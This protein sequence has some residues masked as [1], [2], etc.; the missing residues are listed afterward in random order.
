MAKTKKSTLVCKPCGYGVTVSD[1][2]S[3]VVECW[4]CGVELV[5]EKTVA[6]KRALPAKKAV[7]KAAAKPAPKKAAAKKPA[8]KKAAPKRKK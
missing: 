3:A 6:A 1:L 7:R 2:G 8:A 4:E 5:P